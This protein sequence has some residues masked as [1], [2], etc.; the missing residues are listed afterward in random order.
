MSKFNLENFIAQ[1]NNSFENIQLTTNQQIGVEFW[2]LVADAKDEI[3]DI[4]KSNLVSPIPISVLYE[5]RQIEKRLK[6]LKQ[7]MNKH[8]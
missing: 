1:I 2:K 7:N 8:E 3:L 6:S 5:M 4:E